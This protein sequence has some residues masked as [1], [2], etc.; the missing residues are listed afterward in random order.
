MSTDKLKVLENFVLNDNALI[1]LKHW[2]DRVN[3]FD[4]VKNAKTE[5]RHSS[6]LAWLLDAKESHGLKDA[7]VREFI[8]VAASKSNDGNIDIF[9]WAFMD[10]ECSKVVTEWSEKN[11]AKENSRL[12][13][14]VLF[15]EE[16]NKKLLA[17]ENK[18]TSSEH[19]I[20]GKFQT[21]KYR[22]MLE[23]S[24][25]DYTKMFVYLTPKEEEAK[26]KQW[27]SL[28]Y[29]DITKILEGV[30]ERNEIDVFIRPDV[31]L[32]IDNYREIIYKYLVDDEKLITECNEIYKKYKSA[33]DLIFSEVPDFNKDTSISKECERIWI[34]HEK[35]LSLIK[36]YK[37]SF[38]AQAA[39]E[40]RKVIML[41]EGLR[42]DESGSHTYIMFTSDVLDKHI[43]KNEGVYGSWYKSYDTYRLW[44]YTGDYKEKRKIKLAM[45]LGG[46]NISTEVLAIHK[47]L[48]EK[49][50]K[51]DKKPK[52]TFKQILTKEL[53][54][55]GE[56]KISEITNIMY[57]FIK[58][59]RAWEKEIDTFLT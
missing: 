29:K 50:K 58:E 17:I 7:F 38:L 19:K 16:N 11:N 46:D 43:L 52:Y 21:V 20:E 24:Y 32:I 5:I 31:K 39:Q 59:V 18:T 30:L 28:S 33:L 2:T 22:E 26:D 8:K 14:L 27:G 1:S 15:E 35:E 6:V 40:M 45:E 54:L 4:I 10:F 56:E 44:I 55:S 49:Y 48:I 23:Q 41:N 25:P 51:N 34:R 3:Y 53:K 37:T 36:N 12:D 9:D 42:C 47:K 13:I 57:E